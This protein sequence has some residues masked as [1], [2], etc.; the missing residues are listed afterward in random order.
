VAREGE[1]LLRGRA[2]QSGL[3]CPGRGGGMVYAAAGAEGH[4]EVRLG[5]PRVARIFTCFSNWPF[6]EKQKPLQV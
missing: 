6:G 3:P 1:A 4:A 5:E 2:G